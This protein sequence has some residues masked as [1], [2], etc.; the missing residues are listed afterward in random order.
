MFDNKVNKDFFELAESI[1][2]KE[3]TKDIKKSFVSEE[4]SKKS[5]FN[6]TD[7]KVNTDGNLE[8][9]VPGFTK[10]QLTIT[11]DDNVLYVYGETEN[12]KVNYKYK[13]GKYKVISSSLDLGVL[14][15]KLEKD[16]KIQ[17]IKID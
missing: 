4:E 16:I 12:R 2:G 1:F 14:T 11:V 7:S 9:D 13:L 8:I 15:I 10:E 17:E 3:F 6:K 5:G